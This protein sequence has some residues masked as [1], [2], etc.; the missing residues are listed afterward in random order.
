M[1]NTVL[2]WL[3]FSLIII[4]ISWIIP[5][6]NVE[7]FF[8]AMIACLALALVNTFIKPFLQVITLPINI[9]TLGLFT[10]VI[11]A[12]LFEL[13]AFV[14]PGLEIENFMSAILGALLLSLAS[15]GLNKVEDL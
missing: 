12:I 5:G 4:F 6:I 15:I 2:K 1:L 11:N 9:I 7:N 14:T 10:L 8:S 13:V 3:I